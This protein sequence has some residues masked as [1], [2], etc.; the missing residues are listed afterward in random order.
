MELHDLLAGFVHTVHHVAESEIDGQWADREAGP[1]RLPHQSR[2]ALSD[3]PGDGGARLSDI[4]RRLR[5]PP[6]PPSQGVHHY[7]GGPP[8]PG[9]G[10]RTPAR[11]HRRSRPP[12]QDDAACNSNSPGLT[13]MAA[14][15]FRTT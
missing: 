15:S 6:R 7:R 13:P 1:A 2:H 5:R 14:N 12:T 4:A 8:R 3:A 9:A 11:T 10:A